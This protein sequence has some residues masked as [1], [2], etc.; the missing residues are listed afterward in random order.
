MGVVRVVF[1][2]EAENYYS[3]ST[4]IM[5]LIKQ[6]KLVLYIQEYLCFY[7]IVYGHL[8]YPK[9]SN[10]GY[11]VP[12]ITKSA[13]PYSFIIRHRLVSV[14][15]S[16]SACNGGAPSPVLF[17]SPLYFSSSTLLPLHFVHIV[18]PVQFAWAYVHMNH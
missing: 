12:E 15:A 1:N 7:K 8:G 2:I 17:Q 18:Y 16:S 11:P 13:Q 9:I 3:K 5:T 14:A 6:E 10:F 4:F